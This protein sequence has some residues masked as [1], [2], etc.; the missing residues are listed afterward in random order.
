MG[1]RH[2]PR[3][4]PFLAVALAVGLGAPP[5]RPVSAPAAAAHADT[6][7]RLH[8]TALRSAAATSASPLAAAPPIALP[9]GRAPSLFAPRARRAP[10]LVAGALAGGS[11]PRTTAAARAPPP[12]PRV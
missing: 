7:A 3:A 1:R 4:W 5:A 12:P 6:A 10:E 9:P 11:R 8:H 2:P